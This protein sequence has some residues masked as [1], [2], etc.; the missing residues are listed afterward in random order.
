MIAKLKEE[1]PEAKGEH[2]CSHTGYPLTVVLGGG[3]CIDCGDGG[4][5]VVYFSLITRGN[6]GE[7]L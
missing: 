2:I 1:Q 5:G 4:R 6:L 7:Q 3:E